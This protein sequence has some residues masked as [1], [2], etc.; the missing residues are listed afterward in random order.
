MLKGKI[1]KSREKIK[2]KIIGNSRKI[3]KKLQEKTTK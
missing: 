1:L 2:E 3:F